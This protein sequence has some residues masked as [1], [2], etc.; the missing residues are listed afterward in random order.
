MVDMVSLS[1]NLTRIVAENP[2]FAATL[3]LAVVAVAVLLARPS[4]RSGERP[5]IRLLTGYILVSAMLVFIVAKHYKNYYMIPALVYSGFALSILRDVAQGRG[6]LRYF[7]ILLVPAGML[8][9]ALTWHILIP[10]YDA[11]IERKIKEKHAQMAIERIVGPSDH[12]LVEPTWMAGPTPVNGLVYGISYVVHRHY[13]YNDYE[14]VYPNVLTFE[15]KEKPLRYFRMIDASN[16]SILKSGKAVFMLD[17][18]GRNAATILKYLDSCGADAGIRLLTDTLY[19]NPEIRYNLL[20]VTNANGWETVQDAAF[21]FET[22]NNDEILSDD[23]LKV[24]QGPFRRTR[25]SAGTGLYA[26]ELDGR[27]RQTPACKLTGVV[28]GDR[29]EVSIKRRKGPS[30]GQGELVGSYQAASGEK[31]MH[32]VSERLSSVSP[33]WELVRLEMNVDDQPADSTLTCFYLHRGEGS[34]VVDDLRIR[35]FTDRKIHQD[36]KTH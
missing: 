31:R 22:M 9:I 19:S 6:Y 4:S 35:H 32:A 10:G 33:S 23:G 26:L 30:A 13:F 27:L 14:E 8:F 5:A 2:A 15:G 1:G 36:D 34:Q 11:R 28:K 16:E 20:M 3:L 12:F 7:D 29:I 24:L 21:G 17:T 18:P 25:Q